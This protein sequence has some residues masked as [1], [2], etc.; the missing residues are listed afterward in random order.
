MLDDVIT[1]I[2]KDFVS[3]FRKLTIIRGIIFIIYVSCCKQTKY[4][5]IGLGYRLP[6]AIVALLSL[7][8]HYFLDSHLWMW[9]QICILIIMIEM[10][11]YKLKFLTLLFKRLLKKITQLKLTRPEACTSLNFYTVRTVLLKL[12]H[13]TWPSLFRCQICLWTYPPPPPKPPWQNWRNN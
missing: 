3:L 10:T 2:I 13:S 12:W 1:Q 4:S 8:F 5:C 6:S 7:S 11:F 9:V